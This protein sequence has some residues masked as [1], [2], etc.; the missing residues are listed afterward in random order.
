MTLLNH[1]IQKLGPLDDITATL[2]SLS[3]LPEALEQVAVFRQTMEAM[4]A[5]FTN[6]QPQPQRQIEQAQQI[7]ISTYQTQMTQLQQSID[8]IK[9]K[10]D[11]SPSSPG[12]SQDDGKVLA[13][14]AELKAT[15]DQLKLAAPPRIPH[16]E[17]DQQKDVSALLELVSDLKR[18]IAE[19]KERPTITTQT[20]G[21][22]A[23]HDDTRKILQTLLAEVRV[24]QANIPNA[25]AI[26]FPTPDTAPR[27]LHTTQG[28]QQASALPTRKMDR[29]V[30]PTSKARQDPP[31]F[32]AITKRAGLTGS[33]DPLSLFGTG[34]ANGPAD[35]STGLE[36]DDVFGAVQ[37]IDTAGRTTVGS[38]RKA[39]PGTAPLTATY[40]TIAEALAYQSADPPT[41]PRPRPH[42]SIPDST[43]SASRNSSS[44]SL[45][46]QSKKR[47]T[48]TGGAD[49]A[50]LEIKKQGLL[51]SFKP[52]TRS[53]ATKARGLGI[54]VID[55]ASSDSSSAGRKGSGSAGGQ[56]RTT[57]ASGQKTSESGQ[58]VKQSHKKGMGKGRVRVLPK[59]ITPPVLPARSSQPQVEPAPEPNIARPAGAAAPFAPEDWGQD[60][61]EDAQSQ[62]QTQPQTQTQ[63]IEPTQ[64][65]ESNPDSTFDFGHGQFPS[66]PTLP[67]YESTEN[68]ET[69]AETQLNPTLPQAE[70]IPVDEG[71][72]SSEQV[73][74]S[75]METKVVG[76]GTSIASEATSDDLFLANLNR[77]REEEEATSTPTPTPKRAEP[78]YRRW[79]KPKAENEGGAAK[80]GFFSSLTQK[81]KNFLS[82]MVDSDD[83]D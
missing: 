26:D 43:Q 78:A 24:G 56:G 21:P 36:P 62:S 8:Q 39:D 65:N 81:N 11:S 52:T 80:P 68:I 58:K 35:A 79:Q 64:L 63:D 17:G 25:V 28:P 46:R 20:P 4:Q 54:E 29:P 1:L 47:K 74:R 53:D 50:S 16:P 83:E 71:L 13:A 55:L 82:M 27:P 31:T 42:E 57:S 72:T 34:V 19:M 69:E 76:R 61:G 30:K 45:S 77:P 7:E 49:S 33:R 23:S 70:T 12:T 9:R 37:T 41:P 15:V 59:S 66:V 14:I 75:L 40:S 51:G 67:A 32:K 5:R 44:G 2:A 60:L 6:Q 3:G 18:D 73:E 48:A 38:K 10:V 22:A